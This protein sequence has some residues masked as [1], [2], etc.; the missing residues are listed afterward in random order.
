MLILTHEDK[1][2]IPFIICKKNNDL[3]SK[4]VKIILKAGYLRS[5]LYYT[6]LANEIKLNYTS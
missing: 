6:R 3:P 1:N 5:L 4:R 2:S